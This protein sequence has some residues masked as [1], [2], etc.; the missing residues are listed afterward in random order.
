MSDKRQVA[1]GDVFEV[2]IPMRWSDADMLQHMNNAV[3]FR[4]MEEARILMMAEAGMSST[5]EIGKVV[6]HCSCDFKKAITYPATVRVK[7]VVERVGRTSLTQRNEL[8]VVQD[9]A[10]GPYAVG[11]TV[12]VNIHHASNKAM[13]WTENDL[14]MLGSVCQPN[15]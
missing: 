6:A 2:D 8:S 1:A 12:L 10:A 11:T 4:F 3:Y 7:L 15:D 9:L 14:A 13:P 5:D